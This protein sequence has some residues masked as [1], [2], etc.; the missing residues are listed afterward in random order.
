MAD[1]EIDVQACRG[2]QTRL[3]DVMRAHE[4]DLVVVNQTEHVQWLCG[5]RFPPTMA[6]AAAIDADGKTTIICP[7]KTPPVAAADDLITY[8]AKWHSTL[9]NDQP[10]EVANVVREALASSAR[11]IGVEFS[12]A[13]LHLTRAVAPDGRADWFDIE[14]DLYRLRRRKD[15]DELNRIKR[16]IAATGLMYELARDTIEPGVNEL[17]VFNALQSAAVREFGEMMTGTGN[18][19]Q[20]NARGGPPRDRLAAAGELYIL[21]LGPA[22]RGYFADNARTFAVT[23]SSA[24]QRTAWNAIMEVFHHIESTVQPGLSCR[25][26]FDEVQQMLDRC[27][28][29]VF[30]HHLGHG[31]GLYPHEAP[32]LNPHWNDTFEVGDVFTAEPGLYDPER[33]RAGM[34]IENDYLVTETGVERLTHFPMELD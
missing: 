28:V 4:V 25:Q 11:R 12:S 21:D 26:L 34:R 1:Y 15:A 10:A 17:S 24:D 33:L 32:H 27:P 5:P 20:C 19:F 2:R 29:G 8:E 9:R 16:A 3:L 6:T 14:P 7:H 31:I 30:N 18:D 13:G 22:Y 23:R